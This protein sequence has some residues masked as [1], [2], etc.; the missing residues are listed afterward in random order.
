MHHYHH[1]QKWLYHKAPHDMVAHT[2][3]VQDS[4]AKILVRTDGTVVCGVTAPCALLLQTAHHVK[5]HMVFE[6]VT[7]RVLYDGNAT[8]PN[9]LWCALKVPTILCGDIVFALA[10]DNLNWG[11]CE[12]LRQLTYACK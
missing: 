5:A 3:L 7:A 8:D 4:Y 1:A 9:V 2:A 12:F 10:G 6:H 11:K